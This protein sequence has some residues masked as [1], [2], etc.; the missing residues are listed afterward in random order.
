MFVCGTVS[1]LVEN[2]EEPAFFRHRQG[3]GPVQRS[4]FAIRYKK[5]DGRGTYMYPGYYYA[6]YP[7]RPY[8]GGYGYGAYFALIVVLLV[9][10]LLA[11]FWYKGNV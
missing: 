11:G 2:S 5:G 3:K 8:G 4:W 6:P 1:C 7:Y 10:L 9:L